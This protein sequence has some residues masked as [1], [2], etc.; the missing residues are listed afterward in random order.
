MDSR[1]LMGCYSINAA[2]LQ[3]TSETCVSLVEK[4][5]SNLGFLLFLSGYLTIFA[6]RHAVCIAEKAGKCGAAWDAG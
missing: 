2:K 3:K 1:L 5:V 4:Y 6:T